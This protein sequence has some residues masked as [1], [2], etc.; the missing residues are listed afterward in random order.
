MLDAY[1]P[2]FQESFGADYELLVVVNGS[3]D[4]T[5]SVARLYLPRSQLRVIVE[6]RAIG[7]GGA[8]MLGLGWRAA[9]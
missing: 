8:V 2:Y 6:A 4:A 3:R 1:L 5:E 9:G 7:K